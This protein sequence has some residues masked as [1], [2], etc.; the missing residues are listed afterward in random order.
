MVVY[1]PNGI[2]IRGNEYSKSRGLAKIMTNTNGII[3]A[4]LVAYIVP[5]QR[6][7]AGNLPRIPDAKGHAE[8]IQGSTLKSR[9]ILSQDL[10]R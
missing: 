4:S 6:I 3:K 1:I 8:I 5:G 10:K 2:A 7:F 9:N